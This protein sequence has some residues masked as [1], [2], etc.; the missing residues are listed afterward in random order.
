MRESHPHH[1]HRPHPPPSHHHPPP[2]PHRHQVKQVV[3]GGD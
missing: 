1:F 2:P 3:Q